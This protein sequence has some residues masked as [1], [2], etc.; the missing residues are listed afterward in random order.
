MNICDF[1]YGRDKVLML[2]V[3][4]VAVVQGGI[5]NGEMFC[6]ELWLI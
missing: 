5:R 4:Y 1:K 6:I 3:T 2:F